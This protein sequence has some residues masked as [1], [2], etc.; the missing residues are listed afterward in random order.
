MPYSERPRAWKVCHDRFLWNLLPRR[1][2]QRCR[3]DR[4]GRCRGHI[5]ITTLVKSSQMAR[6]M[7]RLGE[8]NSVKGGKEPLR[9]DRSFLS[10]SLGWLIGGIW[11]CLPNR[12]HRLGHLGHLLFES[13]VGR[14]ALDVS[15]GW[16]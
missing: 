4:I 1:A 8:F 2:W 16:R 11:G 6:A 13:P 10:R 7:F 14:A 9:S 5:F 3:I 15:G 12:A